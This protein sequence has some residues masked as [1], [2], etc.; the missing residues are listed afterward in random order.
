MNL[1]LELSDVLICA[2]RFEGLVARFYSELSKKV[3]DEFLSTVFK[4]VSVESLN[5]A[6]LMSSILKFLNLHY[7]E[8]DCSAVVG[9][10]WVTVMEL[11]EKIVKTDK[12]DS[13][14]VSELLA[15]MKILEKFVGEETYGKLLYPLIKKLIIEA[16]EK[17]RDLRRIE[18][19]STIVDELIEEEKYHEKL[20]DLISDLLKE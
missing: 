8:V 3:E 19:L 18:I 5:H 1:V 17:S 15:G 16:S 11:F 20:A 2:E 6:E 12:A 13:R 7:V 4:W 14:V 10:P 9:E